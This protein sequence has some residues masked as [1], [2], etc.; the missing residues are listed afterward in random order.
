MPM[1]KFKL[2]VK[3]RRVKT[4]IKY[5]YFGNGSSMIT[6]ITYDF[7]MSLCFQSEYIAGLNVVGQ[8]LG[9]KS[10]RTI[11]STHPNNSS[12]RLASLELVNDHKML[13][14]EESYGVPQ[15]HFFTKCDAKFRS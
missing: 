3:R 10:M 6:V 11:L 14:N 13:Q 1:A 5:Q 4:K 8:S 2:Q 7:S 12:S 9:Y 15:G